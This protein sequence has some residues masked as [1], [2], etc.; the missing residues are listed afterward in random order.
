MSVLSGD[1]TVPGWFL[2]LLLTLAAL[3]GALVTAGLQEDRQARRGQQAANERPIRSRQPPTT[4][5]GIRPPARP[6]RSRLSVPTERVSPPWVAEDPPRLSWIWR[7]WE[8]APLPSGWAPT[9]RID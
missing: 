1:V 2:L 3:A 6:R 8:G 7:G 5:T 4:A 9:A